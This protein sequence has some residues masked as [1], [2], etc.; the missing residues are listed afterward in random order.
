MHGRP[1]G[2]ADDPY[3]PL[4]QNTV[5]RRHK[6]VRLH[7]HVQE[8]PQHV[9][10]VIGVDGREHEVARQRRLD[11]D[12][13]GFIVANFAPPLP[14]CVKFSVRFCEVRPIHW[15]NASWRP[16][17][18]TSSTRPINSVLR[19]ICMARCFSLRI[20]SRRVFSSS[21]ILSSMASAAVLGRGEYLKLNSESYCTSSSSLRVSSKSASVSPGK[22]TIMSVVRAM[23]RRAFLIH[24]MRC[25]Y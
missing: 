16:S 24:A 17:T 13:S 10:H 20:M 18:S 25:M 5:Q 4:R 9:H 22:P 23:L 7:A 14:G 8:T 11:G 1:A 3:Q 21:G 12:L 19:R 2:I 6:V 15:P